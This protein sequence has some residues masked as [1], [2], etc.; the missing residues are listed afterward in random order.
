[1]AWRET[2]WQRPPP[3]YQMDST[4]LR[5]KADANI[6]TPNISPPMQAIRS[7]VN[8]LEPIVH[9]LCVHRACL[10]QKDSNGRN[11]LHCCA[12]YGFLQMTKTLLEHGASIDEP[13]NIYEKPQ[14]CTCFWEKQLWFGLETP[15][16][17][18]SGRVRGD[19]V[20]HLLC[21]RADSTARDAA[22]RSWH[23][24]AVGNSHSIR[25]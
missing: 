9:S 8:Q 4:L 24:I 18:A 13:T 5:H 2:H 23:D 14:A 16:I 11:P 6:G 20:A 12:Q 22:D 10:N 7:G 15:L 3:S 19:V 21:Q 17:C 1:M 25:I